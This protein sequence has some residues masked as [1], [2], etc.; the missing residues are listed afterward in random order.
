MRYFSFP[1]IFSLCCATLLT[2]C[3][4]YYPVEQIT[5]KPA[6]VSITEGKRLTMLM[7]GPCHYNASTKDYSGKKLE[8]SPEMLG[9]IYASNIT[10]HTEAGIGSY[11]ASELAY[12]IRTGISRTGKL[13][14]YMKRPN[15]SDED[16]NTIIT[17]LQS[18]DTLVKASARNPGKT[19]YTPI[20]RFGISMSKPLPYPTQASMKLS[21]NKISRGRYL[22][23][24]LACFHCHSKSYPSLN[25]AE[26]EKSKGYMGGGNRMKGAD[27]K[28]IQSPNLTF[29]AT[30][31]ANWTEEDLRKA[32][33][34]GIS[35]NNQALAFPMPLYS[36]LT[37]DEVSSI[38]AYLKSIPPI[39]NN[40]KRKDTNLRDGYS[41][42]ELY[43]N[44]SCKSCH[45]TDGKSPFDLTQ[46][47]NKYDNETLKKYIQN[48]KAFGNTQMPA[49]EN[50]IPEEQYPVLIQY[51]EMLGQTHAPE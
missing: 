26:P 43:T 23:D 19:K 20:G 21:A 14:P 32:L 45:G 37:K 31:I 39:D 51:L 10:R 17:Y 22:V 24:N 44:Y 27:N 11:K 12:L 25:I 38:Y 47:F 33:Q 36:E 15:I 50:I 34:E 5:Y 16:L 4:L 42:K 13:M 28:T 29:H 2:A 8:D 40:V 49:F 48:P 30:G 1:G 18:D 6:Q 46:A 41:G 3:K 9:H 7:C 35:K